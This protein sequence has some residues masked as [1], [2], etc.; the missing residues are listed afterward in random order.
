MIIDMVLS[1]I[2]STD[3]NLLA[4]AESTPLS[5]LWAPPLDPWLWSAKSLISACSLGIESYFRRWTWGQSEAKDTC[6]N[7]Y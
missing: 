3:Q 1:Q 4:D 6:A 2:D 5:F 7:Y